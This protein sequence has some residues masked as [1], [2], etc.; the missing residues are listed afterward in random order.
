MIEKKTS[1]S[2][3]EKSLSTDDVVSADANSSTIE[4]KY[5]WS[6]Q[7]YLDAS[8][9]HTRFGGGNTKEKMIT[10][11][12]AGLILLSVFMMFQRG[13]QPADSMALVLAVY[14]FLLRGRMHK[15]LLLGRF[16][17]SEQKGKEISLII[18][19]E[20]ISARTG[21]KIDGQFGWNEISKVV[22]TGRGFLLYR[23]VNYIWLP[24]AAF[25]DE[26]T[27]ERFA[28]MSERKASSFLDKT[29]G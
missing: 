25:V 5:L 18:D 20:R 13:F 29:A 15:K 2:P 16:H 6:E 24:V 17:K 23:G 1:V 3:S 9:E 14:W 22:R 4:V 7:V 27:C 11:V 26:G 8:E 19:D 12:V 10:L 28:A 21:D